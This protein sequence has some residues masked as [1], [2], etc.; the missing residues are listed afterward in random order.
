MTDSDPDFFALAADLA[1]LEAATVR[2]T[3][4]A[5]TSRAADV[6]ITRAD[7]VRF[8]AQLRHAFR[9]PDECDERAP[10]TSE[11]ARVRDCLDAGVD[12]YGEL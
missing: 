8:V 10:L 12:P 5:E 9:F 2:P 11:G 4:T 3:V 7:R 1:R 6:A